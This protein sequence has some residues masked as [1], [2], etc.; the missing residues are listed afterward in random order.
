ML[1][2]SYDK[3]ISNTQR[4]KQKLVA[5]SKNIIHWIPDGLPESGNDDF[6]G[7]NEAL[8]RSGCW[9]QYRGFTDGEIIEAVADKNATFNPPMSPSELNKVIKQI[10]KYRKGEDPIIRCWKELQQ[11]GKFLCAYWDQSKQKLMV[12][13]PPHL[14]TALKESRQIIKEAWE[15]KTRNRDDE[16]DSPLTLTIEEETEK[17]RFIQK[18]REGQNDVYGN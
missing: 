3:T 15:Q 11:E 1:S 6:S 12:T 9:M 4:E 7:R 16:D 10:L 14:F 2:N 8:F 17:I 13:D 18:M 5:Q